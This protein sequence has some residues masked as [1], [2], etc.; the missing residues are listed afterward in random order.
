MQLT[1]TILQKDN[2]FSV[3][4]RAILNDDTGI[5]TSGVISFFD[6]RKDI[7]MWAGKFNSEGETDEAFK[8]AIKTSTGRG[9]QIKWRGSQ[10]NNP[11]LS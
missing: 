10:L 11:V 6:G 1:I 2:N 5:D 9:W 8:R 3:I 4:G 7:P